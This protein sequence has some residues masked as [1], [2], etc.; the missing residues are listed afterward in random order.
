MT[1]ITIVFI[2]AALASWILVGGVIRAAPRFG[3]VDRPNER[4]LHLKPTPR[5]G[6]IGI[7]IVFLAGWPLAVALIAGWPVIDLW[8]LVLLGLGVAAVSLADDRSP[9]PARLRMI[10]HLAFAAG[11]VTAVGW[12]VYLLVPGA[13]IVNL[14]PFG[15]VLTLLWILGLTNATNF[16]DGAD[17]IAGLQCLVAGFAWTAAG[18]WMSDVAIMVAGAAIAGACCG[19]LFH[20][21]SP[22]QVFMGDVGSAFLGFMFATI[23]ILAA[24]HIVAEAPLAAARIPF[25]GAL[26]MWPFI[27]DGLFTFVRRLLRRENVLQPHRSHLYQRLVLAGWT[28]SHVSLLYGAWAVVMAVAAYLHLSRAGRGLASTTAAALS[29][30]AV[31]LLVKMAERRAGTATQE[32]GDS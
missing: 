26:V 12:F 17:G 5:G 1:A 24:Q 21:W 19:F 3:L 32:T 22:A 13:G 8:W 30:L 20:N 6:G 29:L 11:A 27:G 25:F 2:G 9:I 31:W 15:G 7:V 14:G 16:M 10:V 18:V 28:H 23:P 4:S